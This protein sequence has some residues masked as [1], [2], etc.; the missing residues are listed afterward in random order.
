[1]ANQPRDEE[2]ERVEKERTSEL[3]HE[4]VRLDD[5][6]AIHTQTHRIEVSNAR[7]APRIAKNG[8]AIFDEK[9]KDIVKAQL[10]DDDN[11]G[12]IFFLR[13]SI[14]GVEVP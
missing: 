7:P 1:M 12:V 5:V 8:R 3:W 11:G 6:R 4:A 14:I 9:A 2:A 10:H 13:N